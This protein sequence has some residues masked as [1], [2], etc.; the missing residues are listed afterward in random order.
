VYAV[1]GAGKPASVK[2]SPIN[3]EPSVLVANTISPRPTSQMTN[4]PATFYA[5]AIRVVTTF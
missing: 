4:A 5:A 3:V 1:V 2:D